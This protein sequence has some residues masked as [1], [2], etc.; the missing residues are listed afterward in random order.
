MAEDIITIVDEI[1]RKEGMPDGKKS[2][3][4]IANQCFLTYKLMKLVMTIMVVVRPVMILDTQIKPN[5]K[6]M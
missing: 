1:E 2:R 6:K 3:I 4:C 5:V